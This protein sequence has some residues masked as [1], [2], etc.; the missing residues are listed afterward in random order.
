MKGARVSLE[1]SA[2]LPAEIALFKELLPGMASSTG[3]SDE[4]GRAIL[5][6]VEPGTYDLVAIAQ[7]F[8][9][10]RHVDYE[11][12]RGTAAINVVLERGRDLSGRVVDELLA[13]VSG[14]DVV[15]FDLE[16]APRAREGGRPEDEK[17]MAELVDA[18]GRGSAAATSDRDGRFSLSGLAPGTYRL[19]V[20][21][22]GILSAP[23][24]PSSREQRC[25]TST[26]SA[27]RP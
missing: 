18:A 13:P 19:A 7:G 25:P 20:R 15:V 24:S 22:E 23:S 1:R 17:Q 5:R 2:T 11:V 27:A 3:F 16:R 9:S 8:G 10:R 4:N 26:C 21:G 14:A 6:G 12:G